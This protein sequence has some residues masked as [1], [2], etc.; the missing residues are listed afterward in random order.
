MTTIAAPNPEEIAQSAFD[1]TRSYPCFDANDRFKGMLESLLDNGHNTLDD[2]T[3][4]AVIR[5][6][7]EKAGLA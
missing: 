3:Q 4:A 2:D 7:R 5:A 1:A 6:C